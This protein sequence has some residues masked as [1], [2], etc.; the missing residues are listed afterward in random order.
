MVHAPPP[1]LCRA[2]ALQPYYV[3]VQG[4]TQGLMISVG[5]YTDTSCRLP[6]RP[7]VQILVGGR[8]VR[9]RQVPL[10]LGAESLPQH[11]IRPKQPASF[12][13]RW[14]NWCGRRGP[15]A[16]RL[17]LG[18]VSVV[19]QLGSQ[20]TQGPSCIAKASPSTLGVS[21]FVRR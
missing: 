20:T 19:E 7:E 16:F 1:P 18:G 5:V 17:T 10:R 3:S 11:T 21:L 2:D 13:L 4:A 12:V 15:V 6:A 9:L 8:P 14:E